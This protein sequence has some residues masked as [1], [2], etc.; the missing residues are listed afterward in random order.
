M[1]LQ[2]GRPAADYSTHE[3]VYSNLHV[4]VVPIPAGDFALRMNLAHEQVAVTPHM[5]RQ[6]GTGELFNGLGPPG[7]LSLKTI[8]VDVLVFT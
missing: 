4:E 8:A 7:V 3:T 5:H 2:N 6:F 1:R